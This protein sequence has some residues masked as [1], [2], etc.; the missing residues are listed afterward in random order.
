MFSIF[1]I[2]KHIKTSFILA[3]RAIFVLLEF[4]SASACFLLVREQPTVH[5]LRKGCYFKQ[6]HI[7]E[8]ICVAH[9]KAEI[10]YF[11]H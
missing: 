4:A 8:Y 10:F 5:T 7:S 1:Q 3:F 9:L 11:T 6:S 2:L